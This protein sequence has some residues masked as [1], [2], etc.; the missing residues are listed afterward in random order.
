MQ[1]R[2]LWGH[3]RNYMDTWLGSQEDVLV[4]VG[5]IALIVCDIFKSIDHHHGAKDSSRLHQAGY[6]LPT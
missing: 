1:M 3:G 2:Q 4:Q 6:M 5:G